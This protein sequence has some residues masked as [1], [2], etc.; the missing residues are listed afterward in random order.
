MW[1]RPYVAK[2]GPLQKKF[3]DFSLRVLQIHSNTILRW[4]NELGKQKA[5]N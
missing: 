4:D 3:V 2:S 5:P 1:Q